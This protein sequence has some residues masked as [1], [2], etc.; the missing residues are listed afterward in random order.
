MILPKWENLS[1]E[2]QQIYRN[3]VSGLVSTI[4]SIEYDGFTILTGSN[5]GGKSLIRSQFGLKYMDDIEQN[6][7]KRKCKS[8]SMELRTSTNAEW[9]ALSSAMLDNDA[10]PTSLNTFK[11]IRGVLK[12]AGIFEEH[13]PGTIRMYSDTGF[14]I[15]DEPEIG[16]SEE[17]VLALGNYLIEIFPLLRAE[18]IGLMLITHSRI[19]VDLLTNNPPV[20]NTVNEWYDTF[21][22]INLDGL[23][24]WE[25]ICRIPEPANLELL[26]ANYL[27][28][29]VRERM[30]EVKE[31]KE[32]KVNNNNKGS[33]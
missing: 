29:A 3:K 28:D 31:V 27:F 1:E 18:K 7:N 14:I 32:D 9:G 23:K 8:I 33:K 30:R 13:E 21:K 19:L 2:E 4:D 12:A 11:L 10:T 16:M 26:E 25:Y 5:G 24:L 20:G 6:P 17:M 15:I 22:F